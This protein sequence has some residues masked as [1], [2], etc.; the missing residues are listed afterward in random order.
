MDE[1]DAGL[2][3][4]GVEIASVAVASLRLLRF[5]QDKLHRD[6]R[7]W[8]P[9]RNARIRPSLRAS[10]AREAISLLER[11]L[12]RDCFVP[13]STTGTRNDDFFGEEERWRC[14]CTPKKLSL[15]LLRARKPDIRRQPSN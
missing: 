3:K 13:A 9:S 8:R 1:S 4:T 12:R 14:E 2:V 5:A 11:L 6:D 15:R 7:W 10:A